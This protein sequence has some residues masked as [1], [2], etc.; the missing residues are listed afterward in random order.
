MQLALTHSHIGSLDL[1]DTLRETNQTLH[2]EGEA[3]PLCSQADGA[4]AQSLSPQTFHP[5][6][7]PSSLLT[8]AADGVCSSYRVQRKH[9][10]PATYA[11]ISHT[12]CSKLKLSFDVFFYNLSEVSS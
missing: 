3:K 12:S 9:A 8:Q 11:W 7:R 10:A 6:W 2:E 5:A 1:F 4:Q